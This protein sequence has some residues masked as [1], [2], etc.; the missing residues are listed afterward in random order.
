[1]GAL[2]LGATSELAEPGRESRRRTPEPGNGGKRDCHGWLNLETRATPDNNKNIKDKRER[3]GKAGKRGI[4][5][6]GVSPLLSFAGPGGGGWEQGTRV[7]FDSPLL[8]PRSPE[9]LG[10]GGL[11]AGHSRVTLARS[12]GSGP[13]R[14][15]VGRWPGSWLATKFFQGRSLDPLPTRASPEA[16]S[17]QKLTPKTG[18]FGKRWAEVVIMT[19]RAARCPSATRPHN[20]T[21]K[22]KFSKGPTF[23][24]STFLNQ[25]TPHILCTPT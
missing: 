14:R 18:S 10:P 20:L 25:R 6:R 15:G 16:R 4:L 9:H 12:G 23:G 1:M 5:I 3:E 8:F 2:R 22:T 17:T 7:R 13:E 11:P 24:K 19:P 21:R